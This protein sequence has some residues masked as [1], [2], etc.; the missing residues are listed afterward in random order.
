MKK[1]LI[2]LLSMSTL[3]FT[4]CNVEDKVND[5]L[6]DLLKFDVDIEDSFEVKKTDLQLSAKALAVEFTPQTI[7][8]PVGP[9]KTNID[10]LLSDNN[11]S[12]SNVEAIKAK[13]L[14]L[15]TLTN[16][17][18]F[19][20]MELKLAGK[21]LATI[22][23][24]PAD[25]DEIDITSLSSENLRDQLLNEEISLDVELV[26]KELLE[27]DLKVDILGVFEVQGKINL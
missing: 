10:A 25:K 15:K 26:V 8:I 16:F 4:A 20:R 1:L 24:I 17:N 23:P 11:V 3:L 12:K 14:K 9:I 27:E 13:S 7:N 18:S 5:V 19:Q 21:V 22:D 2:A 6:G